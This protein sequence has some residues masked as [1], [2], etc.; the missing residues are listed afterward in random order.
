MKKKYFLE[1]YTFFYLSVSEKVCTFAH[2]IELDRHIEILLLD[3]DCVI[4]PGLGGFMAHH[5]EARYDEQEKLFLPPLRTPGFNPQLVINDSLLVQSYIEAYDISYPEAFRRIESEVNELKQRIE[6]EGYYELNDVGTLKLNEEGCYVFTPCEAGIL[7]PE[8]YGLSSFDMPRLGETVSTAAIQEKYGNM[9]TALPVAEVKEPVYTTTDSESY[10][11]AITIP[12]SWVR[13]AVAV[14]AA[15]IA[16]F[17]ITTPVSNSRQESIQS[18]SVLPVMAKSAVVGEDAIEREAIHTENAAT[19]AEAETEDE[20][21]NLTA[22]EEAPQQ[23]QAPA[24]PEKEYCIVLASHV[25]KRNAENYVNE[26]RQKGYDQASVYVRK[27]VVRVIYGS[28]PTE[29]MAY[30]TAHK[31]HAISGFEEAWVMKK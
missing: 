24:A 14:A 9:E 5:M 4:V 29:S 26:L 13:N 6:N 21:E 18:S 12:M 17:L 8:L 22:V 20:I 7:T 27:G 11:H 1:N 16:F 31:L 30:K 25:S 15:I 3:N 2:V 10:E 28:Y 19:D 23:V